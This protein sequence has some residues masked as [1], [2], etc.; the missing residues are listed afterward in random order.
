MT[1]SSPAED[2]KPPN[3]QTPA[4]QPSVQPSVVCRKITVCD[5][6]VDV[7][8]SLK[9]WGGHHL[10][11][12]SLSAHAPLCRRQKEL[13]SFALYCIRIVNQWSKAAFWTTFRVT[14]G[15]WKAGTSFLKRLVGR[16]LKLSNFI[17]VSRKFILVSFH[18]RKQN[19]VKTIGFLG[20]QEN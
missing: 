13:L 7:K 20:P 18:R 15:Y 6:P 3:H 5:L 14:D 8:S 12:P 1:K 9:G 2:R 17:E 4:N 10:S 11:M 16:I 19:I